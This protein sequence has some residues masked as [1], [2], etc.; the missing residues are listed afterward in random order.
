IP[1]LTGVEFRFVRLGIFEFS[2]SFGI[3]PINSF[4]QNAVKLGPTP[5]DLSTGHAYNL[6][7]SSIYYMNTLGAAIRCFPFSHGL[8]FK[9]Q[10]TSVNLGASIS[11]SLKDETTATDLG[12]VI[13][14]SLGINQLMVG[15]SVGY[16]WVWFQR[17][18][19]EL[20]L[21]A[22][23]LVPATSSVS[24]T[25]DVAKIAAFAPGGGTAFNGAVTQVQN[26]VASAVGAYS[27]LLKV[28][29]TAMIAIGVVF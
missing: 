17:M 10:F 12:N 3:F 7:P 21:G 9:A 19:F 23:Y 14:G 2:G 26:G 16:Q 28:L 11:G 18:L 20:S 8:F 27:S 4:V 22:D 13:T 6:Y 24:A 29:P 1:D 5:V 25:G 15:L